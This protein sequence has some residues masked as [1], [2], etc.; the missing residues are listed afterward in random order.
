[1]IILP[2]EEKRIE[3]RALIDV[4]LHEAL[5]N[6]A[7]L[8]KIGMAQML[9]EILKQR[10]QPEQ[11]QTHNFIVYHPGEPH[12]NHWREH[13]KTHNLPYVELRIQKSWGQKQWAQ[14]EVDL[15]YVDFRMD[16]HLIG[17]IAKLMVG[18]PF[19]L[20]TSVNLKELHIHNI[21]AK[22]AKAVAEEV[23]NLLLT[24]IR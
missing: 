6:E 17:N 20:R 4:V 18:S 8:Y 19:T 24:C 2:M 14:M 12:S 9:R 23:T 22:H 15:E 11:A 10:Y 1:M 5:S 13:C 7:K 3:V 16:E 21:D